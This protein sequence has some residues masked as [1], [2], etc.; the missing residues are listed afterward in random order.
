MRTSEVGSTRLPGWL[1]A[2]L[3]P[4]GLIVAAPGPAVAPAVDTL[5]GNARQVLV[6]VKLPGA[7][8]L[9]DDDLALLLNILK[10]CRL[11]LPDVR[12]V[13][14]AHTPGVDHLSLARDHRPVTALLFGVTPEDIGLPLR[15]P[16]FQVQPFQGVSYLGSPALGELPADPEAKKRLWAGLRQLFTP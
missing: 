1:L 6:L 5:G 4:E 15:F 12:V 13:N 11:G 9:P 3:Y 7:A 10:A 2:R 16:P 8:V 14:L